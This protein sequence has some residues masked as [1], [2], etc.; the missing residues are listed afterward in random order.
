[1]MPWRWLI[2]MLDKRACMLLAGLLL[3]GPVEP[4]QAVMLEGTGH[5]T[6]HGNDLDS[7]R[8]EARR[9]ALRDVA[10]Q[11]EARIA[12]DETVENGVI[13]HSRL[14]VASRARARDVRVIN[15]HRTGDMLRLTVLADMSEGHS[16]EVGGAHRMKKRVAV[17]GFPILYPGE[18]RIGR[19]DDAGEIL[20]QALQA[21]L[22]SEG[23]L[24]IFGATT[25]QLFGDL[26]NAPT[27]QRFDNS[28]TNVIELAKELDVQFVVSG[29]IRDMAIEDPE[30]WGS[31]ILDQMQRGIGVANQNRRFVADL[32][33]FD[34]FSGAPV[35]RE[36][37]STEGKWDASP[38]SS[39]GF[40][41]AG[42]QQTQYGEAVTG[43]MA[44]MAEAVNQ[45]LA[46]QPFITRI[47]RVEG[48]S[49]TLA[50]GAI[51]G[52]RPGDELD[53]YRSYSY[54][55][56]PG[57]TPEL[58]DSHT[59]VRIDNVHPD[60]SNGLI[61]MHGGQINIQRNDIAIIW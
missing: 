22:H 59:S 41:S 54:F 28:L 1:M 18:A 34:G 32:M 47:T 51:A 33:V 21:S 40:G 7:A 46:C 12:S 6:I 44:Q 11:Y 58:R 57:A 16:C 43:L 60:F 24:Q 35:F 30:A 17:T 39:V 2:R 20:P 56:S 14:T 42:F 48:Q 10:L 13:T 38:K 36:R 23:K 5:A 4:L 8:E 27:Q 50:S 25:V 37:F 15:E 45:A 3:L 26:L 49:V 19:L 55:D 9:S 52:I 53:L 61:P 29:V 31:S